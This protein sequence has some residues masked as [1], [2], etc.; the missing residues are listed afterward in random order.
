M[1]YILIVL[2]FLAISCNEKTE[3]AHAH[4]ADGSHVGEEVP[5]TGYTIWTDKTELFVEFPALIVGSQSRFA[6][7]LTVLKGHQPVRE[8]TVTV[9]L[10]KDGKGIRST[11]DAPSSPGIFSPSIQPKEAGT[12]QLVFDITAP[13]L[14]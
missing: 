3:E 5:R 13:S 7:H 10:I 4:N 6:A 14:K 1:K 8:G 2:A 11:A 12:Y 9:S